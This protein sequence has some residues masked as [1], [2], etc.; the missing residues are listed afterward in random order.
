MKYYYMIGGPDQYFALVSGTSQDQAVARASAILEKFIA[1]AD[2]YDADDFTCTRL[3]F[4]AEWE[5][6]ESET[7]AHWNRVADQLIPIH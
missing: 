6:E 1:M 7:L 3:P 4:D 2:K 5:S